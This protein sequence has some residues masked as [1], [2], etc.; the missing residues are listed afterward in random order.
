VDKSDHMMNVLEF[1][2]VNVLH[3]VVGNFSRCVLVRDLIEEM[4]TMPQ[5]QITTQRKTS[6]ID[7]PTKQ[8]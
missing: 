8:T 6:P 2:G 7:Q 5:T 3:L 4:G 1:T